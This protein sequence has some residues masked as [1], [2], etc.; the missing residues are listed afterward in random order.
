MAVAGLRGM[1]RAAVVNADTR[2]SFHLLSCL[3][4]FVPAYCRH[5]SPSGCRAIPA[6]PQKP[7]IFRGLAYGC[8][9][10]R[11]LSGQWEASPAQRLVIRLP[12]CTPRGFANAGAAATAVAAVAERTSRVAGIVL[13]LIVES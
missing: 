4:V 11:P 8:A 1:A 7:L 13:F 6:L 3:L 5:A 10:G 2:I 9:C 12:V